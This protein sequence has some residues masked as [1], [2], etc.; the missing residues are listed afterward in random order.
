MAE[1][2]IPDSIEASL[3]SSKPE[4]LFTD[5]YIDSFETAQEAGGQG[6]YTLYEIHVS[7]RYSYFLFSQ[8]SATVTANQTVS[9][10]IQERAKI[11]FFKVFLETI[12]Y[13]S[14]LYAVFNLYIY[15]YCYY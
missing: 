11:A 4:R 8:Q 2:H 5:I 13:L 9:E 12:I 7:V 14:S 1:Q 15:Y 6:T 3:A 10:H